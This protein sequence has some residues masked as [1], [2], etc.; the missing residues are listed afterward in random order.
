MYAKCGV[1]TKAAQVL[2]ELPVR[3]VV[4]W[5]AIIAGYAQHQEGHKALDCL[6]RMQRE[7]LSP[8]EVTLTCTLH[9]CANVGALDKGKQIHDEIGK[10]GFL[11]KSIV[12]GN[13]LVDMYAKCGVLAK[14]R[15]VVDE[16]PARDIISWNTLLAGYAQDEQG[17][18]ALNCLTWMQREG[19]S[20]DDITFACILKACGGM[21]AIDKGKHIHSE[22]LSRG[23]L[24]NNVVLGNSLVDMYAKCSCVSNAK[25]V[26]EELPVRNV[27]SW[28]T[29]ITGFAQHEQGHEA[30]NCFEQMQTDGLPPNEVTFSCILKACGSIGAIDKGLR[31]HDAIVDSGFLQKSIVLATALVDMY[32]KCGMLARA[33]QVLEGLHV[34]DVVSWSV[35]IAGYAQDGQACKALDCFQRMQKEGLCPD[36]VTFVCVLNACSHSGNLDMAQRYYEAMSRNY[37]IAPKLEHH[38][39]MVVIFGS[40]GRFDKVMSVMKTMSSSNETSSVWLALLGACRKWGNV[41][42]GRLAFD[43]ATHLDKNVATAYVAMAN[44]YAAAGMYDDAEKVEKMRIENGACK[45]SSWVDVIR[46]I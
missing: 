22:I 18:E 39:C 35:L 7:G 37:G 17:H 11:R 16:L 1:L 38:T 4:C 44:I 45:K 28:N 21:R 36:E 23:L 25:Q 34:R 9:A 33:Q 3:N 19:I 12:L 15:E 42:L 10:R 2:D 27:V 6:A 43:Q 8:D 32:A 26:L 5:N 40:A 30:L 29:L 20:A 31:I 13:A 46:K 14:A 24:G 41:K